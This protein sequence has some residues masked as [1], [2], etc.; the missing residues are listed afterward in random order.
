M[1]LISSGKGDFVFRMESCKLFFFFHHMT[2]NWHKDRSAHGDSAYLSI[3]SS[4]AYQDSHVL[5]VLKDLTHCFRRQRLSAALWFKKKIWKD[6]RMCYLVLLI[7]LIYFYS[8]LKQA[9]CL[10]WSNML[11]FPQSESLVKVLNGIF[12]F[13][14]SSCLTIHHERWRI[15]IGSACTNLIQKMKNVS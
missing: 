4:F 10:L 12:D 6:T 13:H 5:D 3:H 7:L 9:P 2:V 8:T 15:W 1:N 14:I 11:M